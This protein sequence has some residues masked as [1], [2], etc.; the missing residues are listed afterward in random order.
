MPHLQGSSI[1]YRIAVGAQKGCKT[2]QLQ[3]VVAAHAENASSSSFLVAKVSGFSLHAGVCAQAHKRRKLE[4][5]CRYITRPAISEKRLSLT[6]HGN[7]RIQLKTAYRDGTTHVILESLDFMAHL[8]VRNPSGDL[9]SCK[10]AI[11]PICHRQ[12]GGVS[13][14]A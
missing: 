11:L 13:S 8:P 4:Q 2:F 10:S 9:W 12:T 3:T 7:V 1:Q 5:L 14:G 6:S